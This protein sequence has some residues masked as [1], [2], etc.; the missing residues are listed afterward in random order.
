M[1][2]LLFILVFIIPVFTGC[3]KENLGTPKLK[4]PKKVFCK[5]Q[6]D[7]YDKFTKKVVNKYKDNLL[8]GE[9]IYYRGELSDSIIYTYNDYDLLFREEH[10]YRSIYHDPK[11]YKYKEI[12]SE[13]DDDLKLISKIFNYYKIN[14][15]GRL[16]FDKKGKLDYFYEDGLLIK[17]CGSAFCDIYKYN[18]HGELIKQLI[19]SAK[20][21]IYDWYEYEYRHGHKVKE[22]MRGYDGKIR[23]VKKFIY[24]PFWHLIKV[25]KDDN[26]I[27]ENKYFFNKLVEKKTYYFGIDPGFYPCRGNYVY[28]YEY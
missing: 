13:Y 9:K 10:Y 17:S 28:G 11:Y 6:D 3:L 4:K 14:K 15:E 19:K 16:E 22:I 1:K 18:D 8:T 26:I 20:G 2:Q 23:Y 21:H 12:I 5:C 24:D 27:E 25:Q 7:T